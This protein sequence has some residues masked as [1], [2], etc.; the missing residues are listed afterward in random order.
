MRLDSGFVPALAALANAERNLGHV[1]EALATAMVKPLLSGRMVTPAGKR[2]PTL[3]VVDWDGTTHRRSRMGALG[4]PSGS[5]QAPS[6]ASGTAA[7]R[8]RSSVRAGRLAVAESDGMGG[9]VGG[10]R[11]R[12]ELAG[13]R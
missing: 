9:L 2:L 8:W 7:A 13:T 4:T 11:S 1:T 6:S 12:H 10:E 5:P 3:I